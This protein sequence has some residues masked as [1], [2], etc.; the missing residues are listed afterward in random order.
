MVGGNGVII[1]NKHINPFLDI[2]VHRREGIFYCTIRYNDMKFDYG[3]MDYENIGSLGNTFSFLLKF[4]DEKDNDKEPQIHQIKNIEFSNNNDKLNNGNEITMY[5]ITDRGIYVIDKQLLVTYDVLKKDGK[6]Q[7]ETF[8]ARR[9]SKDWNVIHSCVYQHKLGGKYHNFLYYVTSDEEKKLKILYYN[10]DDIKVKI[11]YLE[12]EESK[13]FN[14][15]KNYIML[16]NK[17]LSIQ[18]F[19]G[20]TSLI[21]ITQG[22]QNVEL[23]VLEENNGVDILDKMRGVAEPIRK[24]ITNGPI[25][26]FICSTQKYITLISKNDKGGCNLTKYTYLK[27][28]DFGIYFTHKSPLNLDNIVDIESYCVGNPI[29]LYESSGPLESKPSTYFNFLDKEGT[30]TISSFREKSFK[31]YNCISLINSGLCFFLNGNELEF[32]NIMW[33]GYKGAIDPTFHEDFNL[34]LKDMYFIGGKNMK[35]ITGMGLLEMNKQ[36][37]PIQMLVCIFHKKFKSLHIKLPR[38]I[39]I[40]ILSNI[41]KLHTD[42]T[43]KE[44]PE[45]NQKGGETTDKIV[46]LENTKSFLK[47][48]FEVLKNL[49]YEFPNNDYVVNDEFVNKLLDEKFL[50]DL[51]SSTLTQSDNEYA[52]EMSQS[53]MSNTSVSETISPNKLSET[54]DSIKNSRDV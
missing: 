32:G 39:V 34:N 25:P 30:I 8:V 12:E 51:D 7:Y 24:V 37:K 19:F 36:V 4:V 42:M 31:R 40:I 20:S 6:Y 1:I 54:S 44:Y 52:R 18:S 3:S 14:V 13:H 11:D 2:S 10:N 35:H 38:N 23:C 29:S 47:S 48:L 22:V 33:G 26:K 49:G 27:N 50:T 45:S 15:Y 46:E 5:F 41:F 16:N 21:A 53:V 9:I 43:N 17:I 28:G